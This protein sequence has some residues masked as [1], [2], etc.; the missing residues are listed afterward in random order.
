ML[1]LL[2]RLLDN[3]HGRVNEGANRHSNSAE[4]HDVRS[5]PGELHRNKGKNDGDGNDNDG[6]NRATEVPQEDEDDDE[7]PELDELLEIL[8][9]YQRGGNTCRRDRFAICARKC[10]RTQ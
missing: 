7:E 2:V 10:G 3:N 8:S 6:H 5:H 1:E 9:Y 4:R